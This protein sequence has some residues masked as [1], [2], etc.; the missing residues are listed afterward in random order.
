[1][2]IVK[3]IP[4][5]YQHGIMWSNQ[6]TYA[7]TLLVWSKD[8]QVN[9]LCY[10]FSLVDLGKAAKHRKDKPCGAGGILQVHLC[11]GQHRPT[12]DP[13]HPLPHLPSCPAWQLVCSSGSHADVP[14]SRCR[15]A[16]RHPHS[17]L[18]H[19]LSYSCPFSIAW[20]Y[21]LNS[22]G[23]WHCKGKYYIGHMYVCTKIRYPG[24]VTACSVWILK[25]H[26]AYHPPQTKW[27]SHKK[28]SQTGI[29]GVAL[30]EDRFTTALKHNNV[31]LISELYVR[32]L[33][34]E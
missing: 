26:L 16:L 22:R 6:G 14:S 13:G 28:F 11:Q 31:G 33:L 3:R 10:N 19:I 21:I 24:Q 2:H 12:A 18:A 34:L 4:L 30:N 20:I 5:T 15:S 29:K 1:M 8:T 17:G 27:G 25:H 9:V 23:T 32:F 7:W